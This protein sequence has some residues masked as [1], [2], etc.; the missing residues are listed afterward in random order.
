MAL[1]RDLVF[2]KYEKTSFIPNSTFNTFTI[3]MAYHNLR[4]EVN[5]K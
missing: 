5:D 1:D 2:H 3:R 4:I